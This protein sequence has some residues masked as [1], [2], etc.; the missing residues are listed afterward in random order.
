MN[1]LFVWPAEPPTRLAGLYGAIADQLGPA[2]V[3]PI[4]DPADLPD[5]P[6]DPP[7]SAVVVIVDSLLAASEAGTVLTGLADLA[8]RQVFDLVVVVGDGWLGTDGPRSSTGMV[9]AAAVSAVRSLAVRSD[10][11]GRANVISVPEALFGPSGTQRAPLSQAVEPED[12]AHA[13]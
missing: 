3:V 2:T 10:R 8:D 6:E 13:V 1:T 12:V 9:E 5:L 7:A 11:S 4:D